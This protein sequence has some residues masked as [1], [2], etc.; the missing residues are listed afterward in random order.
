MSTQQ[1]KTARIKRKLIQQKAAWLQAFPLTNAPISTVIGKVEL[2][3]SGYKEGIAD[4]IEAVE[5]EGIT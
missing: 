2:Y 1:S 4:A 5:R 3:L